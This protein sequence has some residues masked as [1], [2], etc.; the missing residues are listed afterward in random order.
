MKY[1][2]YVTFLLFSILS[3]SYVACQYRTK[4]NQ[5]S[6]LGERV[7]QLME[8]AM[9][10]SVQKFNWP[11]FKQY[12]KATPRNYSV[13]VMFTAMAPQRQCQICR[14]AN[15]EFNIVANSFRY[16]QTYSNKLYFVSID[17]DEG[18]DVFQLMRL[19]TAPVYMHF[20]PKGK[21]KP[22]DTMDIQRVGFSAEAIAKWISER[23]D[24]QIRVFRPPNYSGTIALVMLLVIIGSFL[25]LRRN[26]LDF[27]H[28]RGIWGLGALFLALTMTSGQM[29]NH[30][31]GPPLIHRAPNG[32]VAYIHGSSQGQFILETYIVFFL[33][34]AVVLGM[35][36]MTEAATRKGDVKKRRI[37]AV[38]G[39]ALV[40]IFFS[41]L[42]SIFRNKAQ[43]YPYSLLFK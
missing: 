23:T 22:A 42:L 15:D 38:I 3:L 41:L 2:L 1:K 24:I 13:I 28:N 20:P 27:I 19:N 17:F 10:R 9:K 35:I 31:R 8:M 12:I 32:N 37:F 29:W 25:Y 26:N 7:Q 33:N 36:L 18:S 40:T 6:S 21:P 14:H 34:A 5:G 11:K 30:I 39:L 4:N 16:S 43:G